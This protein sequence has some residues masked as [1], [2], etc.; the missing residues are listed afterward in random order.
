MDHIKIPS[1]YNDLAIIVK[2]SYTG[3]R[4]KERKVHT[5]AKGQGKQV[6]KLLKSILSQQ[7]IVE[8]E[9]QYKCNIRLLWSVRTHR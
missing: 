2:K 6:F 5:H 7:Y 1:R 9:Q 4:G 3:V 8:M